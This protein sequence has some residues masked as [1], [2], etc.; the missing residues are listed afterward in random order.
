MKTIV[1]VLLAIFFIQSCTKDLSC[2]NEHEVYDMEAGYKNNI[3]YK[4]TSVII[5]FINEKSEDVVYKLKNIESN[6]NCYS[7]RPYNPNC[8]ENTACD[9]YFKYSFFNSDTS[10][11]L[12]QIINSTKYNNKIAPGYGYNAI[13][14]GILSI[15]FEFAHYYFNY[16]GR[17][18]VEFNK[19]IYNNL[20]YSVGPNVLDTLFYNTQ[21]G[22]VAVKLN[23]GKRLYLK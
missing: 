22:I 17:K 18:D 8:T 13:E 14:I 10:L 21:I 6:Y 1:L 2:G 23:N 9:Q 15:N 20:I 11:S 4:D 5:N 19:K 16:Y 3:P 12:F 7:Y